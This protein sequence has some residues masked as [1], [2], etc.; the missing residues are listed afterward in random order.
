MTAI[1]RQW[2]TKFWEV[3]PDTKETL[4]SYIEKT[5]LE[6]RGLAL[7]RNYST[8]F[9]WWDSIDAEMRLCK[10]LEAAYSKLEVVANGR[11]QEQVG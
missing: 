1:F 9:S 10:Y 7:E 2:H 4:C 5:K 11:N 6:L 3:L 8:M